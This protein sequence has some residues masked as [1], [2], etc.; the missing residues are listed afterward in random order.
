MRGDVPRGEHWFDFVMCSQQPPSFP[1][2]GRPA[3]PPRHRHG[4][5]VC[6]F[7]GDGWP[8]QSLS[9]NYDVGTWQSWS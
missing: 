5:H 3:W 2:V 7:G 1:H 6:S 9:I 8:R 4:I